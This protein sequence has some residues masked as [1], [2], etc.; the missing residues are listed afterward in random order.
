MKTSHVAVALL[1]LLA[2]G[3]CIEV[4]PLERVIKLLQNMQDKGTQDL[5]ADAAQ[6]AIYKDWCNSTISE[7]QSSI[8]KATTQLEIL[9]A[10]V[11]ALELESKKYFNDEKVAQMQLDGS[12]S[13]MEA[14][15]K[16]RST[17]KTNYLNTLAEY[18]KALAAIDRA[19][20]SLGSG[21]DTDKILREGGISFLQLS[22]ALSEESLSPDKAREEIEAFIAENESPTALGLAAQGSVVSREAAGLGAK[23]SAKV[24]DMLT[25][26]K[27]KFSKERNDL[28]KKE[29]GNRHTYEL[30]MQDLNAQVITA[31]KMKDDASSMK[32]AKSMA[33]AEKLGQMKELNTTTQEDLKYVASVS[34]T[35]AQKAVDFN[36]S[37]TTRKE[38]L[39]A[40]KQAITILKGNIANLLQMHAKAGTALVVL[41][42]SGVDQVRT[43]RVLSLLRLRAKELNSRA[44]EAL[45]FRVSPTDSMA[46]VRK[47]LSDMISQLKQD[48]SAGADKQ[49]WCTKELSSNEQ[50]RTRKSQEVETLTAAVGQ[51]QSDL[52]NLKQDLSRLAGEISTANS[53]IVNASALRRQ[54]SANNNAT[55][56]N[57]IDAT[58]AVV[59][60]ITTLKLFYKKVALLQD[61]SAVNTSNDEAAT[62]DPNYKGSKYSGMTGQSNGVVA[63]LEV[64][65]SDYDRLQTQTK[66]A[67]EKAQKD[68]QTFLDESKRD[69]AADQEEMRLKT[70]QHTSK[71]SDLQD[72]KN[73]LSISQKALDGAQT[74]YKE[75]DSQ[76]LNVSNVFSAKIAQRQQEIQSLKDAIAAFDQMTQLGV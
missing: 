52:S 19:M 37:Q 10:D 59:Q 66:A 67:E 22:D 8:K 71:T 61:E 5:Q 15:T 31:Q 58:N 57:A 33:Q 50:T 43:E 26:L 69:I 30:L 74:Y 9:K 3:N 29:L 70:Q 51:L 49:A 6:Y 53:A 41:H 65:Q 35:C 44:L 24:M 14:A 23:G 63:M 34:A 12:K 36:A 32:T 60:A 47:M 16:D 25:D 64:V 48:Q 1:G 56:K 45:S 2:F 40:V 17:E 27:D 68:F 72:R 62:A 54:E 20:D 7:K 42:S 39:G 11:P 75:L 76:C 73:D 18:T 28:E 4:T 46:S 13:D 55:I 38:E 21:E